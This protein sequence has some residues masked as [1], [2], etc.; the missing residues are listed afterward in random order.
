MLEIKKLQRKVKCYKR[1]KS[2]SNNYEYRL[3]GM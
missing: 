3:S 2:Y 1:L